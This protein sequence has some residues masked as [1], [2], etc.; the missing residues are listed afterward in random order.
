MWEKESTTHWTLTKIPHDHLVAPLES[1]SDDQGYHLLLPL[2]Q[3]NLRSLLL[4]PPPK[5]DA[6][7][8]RWLL[9]EFH[10]LTDGLRHIHE[11]FDP[12]GRLPQ[13][14]FGFHH[15]IKPENILVYESRCFNVSDFGVGR[16]RERRDTLKIADFGSAY[17]GNEESKMN[18]F[19][20][21]EYGGTR[22]YESPEVESQGLLSQ[23]ADMWSLGCILLE[24]LA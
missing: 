8:E 13:R 18:S 10:G 15:D 9:T 21:R 19:L 12:D 3:S 22:V 24:M 2:A 11:V 7:L 23:P 20:R 14:S 16:V 17:I 4:G 1:W 5:L 6:A